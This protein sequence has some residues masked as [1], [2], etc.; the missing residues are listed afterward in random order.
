[1]NEFECVIPILNV[2]SFAASI[3][4]YV[5]KL[6]F[7]KKWDWGNPAVFGCVTRGNV[8]IL[9]C[10]GAQ[11]HPGTWVS[12]FVADVDALYEEYKSRDV[13]IRQPP[14]N[15]PWGVRE[16]N[17]E[18]LDGHRL[19]MGSDAKEPADPTGFRRFQQIEQP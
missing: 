7:R 15:L 10:E 12:I 3:D 17:V 11:G 9:F 4:Y 19:R 1:M 6:G 14:T 8:E 18:D 2:K 16:M 5:N 13:I